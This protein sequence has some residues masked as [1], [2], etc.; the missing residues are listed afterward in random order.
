MLG[1]TYT[2]CKLLLVRLSL[3]YQLQITCACCVYL[4]LLFNRN[5][6][7]SRMCSPPNVSHVCFAGRPVLGVTPAAEERACTAQGSENMFHSSV[8]ASKWTGCVRG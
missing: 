8:Q 3:L 4:G 5:R 6:C 7:G 1:G 2:L